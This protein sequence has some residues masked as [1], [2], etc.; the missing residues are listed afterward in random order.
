[1]IEMIKNWISLFLSLISSGSR[2]IYT[3]NYKMLLLSFPTF[4]FV[5]KVSKFLKSV[6]W[7]LKILIH[8]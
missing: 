7:Y 1:M 5:H 8:K 4:S 2:D 3:F 6:Y